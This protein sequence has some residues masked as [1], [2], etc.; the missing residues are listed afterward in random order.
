MNLQEN[1]DNV[2]ILSWT[3]PLRRERAVVG[4][5]GR[6]SEDRGENEGG[7][8]GGMEGGMEGKSPVVWEW[9]SALHRGWWFLLLPTSH[10]RSPPHTHPTPLT[11]SPFS[12]LPRFWIQLQEGRMGVRWGYVGEV[13]R[14]T[15]RGIKWQRRQGSGWM[16]G[17]EVEQ[18]KETRWLCACVCYYLLS[19][20]IKKRKKEVQKCNC[21]L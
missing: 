8:A 9:S 19:P 14:C 12:P 10:P 5:E 2:S 13:D 6:W 17:S 7:R 4:W 15:V 1:T 3:V 11:S 21:W 20:W 16:S 18:V